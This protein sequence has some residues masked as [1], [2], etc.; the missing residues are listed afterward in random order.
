MGKI[1]ICN[2]C[3]DDRNIDHRRWSKRCPPKKDQHKKYMKMTNFVKSK[4]E[5]SKY[6][7]KADYQTEPC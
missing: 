5:P 2:M 7:F 6:N 1:V 4:I 3:N